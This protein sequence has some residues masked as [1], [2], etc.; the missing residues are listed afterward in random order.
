[1]MNPNG[2]F[3]VKEYLRTYWRLA[4]YYKNFMWPGRELLKRT[5][6]LRG[7]HKGSDAFVFGCGPSINTLDTYKINKYRKERGFKVYA[8]NSYITG[9]SSAT[10]IPDY[11]VLSDPANLGHPK[12]EGHRKTAEIIWQR[13]KENHIPVFMPA[14]LHQNVEYQDK[15]IFCDHENLYSANTTDPLVSRGFISLTVL[16]AVQIALFLGHEKIYIGGVD[17][18][19]IKTFHVNKDNKILYNETHFYDGH[20]SATTAVWD[21]GNMLKMFYGGFLAFGSYGRFARHSII[22]LNPDSFVDC[23]IKQ[24]DL[25]VYQ[26]GSLAQ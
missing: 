26:K 15:Y 22:N 2:T 5:A 7:V 9:N 18:D 12:H 24:H 17:H 10:V 6:A 16:K 23:F 3:S 1:M 21:R 20:H 19:H 4:R 13:L 8:L 11:Y 14:D 25:D